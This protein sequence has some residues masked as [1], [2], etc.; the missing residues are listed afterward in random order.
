MLIGNDNITGN[1]GNKDYFKN[2]LMCS[3][4]VLMNK[5]YTY[6]YIRAYNSFFKTKIIANALT[7]KK[8][9]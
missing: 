9:I 4:Y 8:I 3:Q 6:N 7:S 2:I 5:M 1:Q